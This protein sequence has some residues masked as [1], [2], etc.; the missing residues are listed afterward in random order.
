MKNLIVKWLFR[1][2]LPEITQIISDKFNNEIIGRIIEIKQSEFLSQL[3]DII[4]N[5]TSKD[6]KNKIESKEFLQS[7]V[8]EINNLQLK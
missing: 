5:D 1:L 7:V 2:F 8:N 3:R 4:R 6:F